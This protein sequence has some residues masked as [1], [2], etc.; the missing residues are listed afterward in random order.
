MTKEKL[1]YIAGFL[2][3]DGCI[4]LQLIYRHDY[5]LGYQIRA[6]VVFYQK[7]Q[8]KD[9][10]AWLKRRL[11]AGY[12]RERPDNISEYTIV[13]L[14]PVTKVLN[15]LYPYLRLKKKQAK[16]ALEV[17]SKMPGQ[18]RDMKPKLLL[19]LS[20]KVDKFADL[21]YSKKRTNTSRQVEE[22][23]KS[24]NLLIP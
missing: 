17:L 14:K 9:F 6:S 11:I 24:R 23:L 1:A 22:F 8:F 7:T 12:I 13:G 18:G 15:L 2:D 10:L 16:L 5:K 3:G 21:N 20:R 19:A 4:L